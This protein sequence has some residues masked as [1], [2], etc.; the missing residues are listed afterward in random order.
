MIIRSPVLGTLARIRHGFSTRLGGV[1][2][3]PFASLNVDKSAED[4]EGRV[5]ENRARL[6]LMIG[7]PVDQ[8]I[9]QVNQVH[10]T[11]ILMSSVAGEM[12]ADGIIADAPGTA[13]GVRTAD[14]VPILIACLDAHGTPDAVAA[15]HAGWRGATGG[16]LIEAVKRLES[17][18]SMP[19]RMRFA[20]GPAIRKKDFEVGVE[21]VEAARASLDGDPPPASQRKNGAWELDLFALLR[22]HLTRL[23]VA[24]SQIDDVG[25]STFDTPSLYFSHRRD[26]GRTGRHLA[27]IGIAR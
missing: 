17:L 8:E 12:P 9:I 11:T 26:Q 6:K 7:L 1:S 27:V 23:D 2:V 13:V 15:V 10:G 20:L 3:G 21:V 18:G 16:I 14:C 5:L 4:D 22:D 25:G 19:S 24:P